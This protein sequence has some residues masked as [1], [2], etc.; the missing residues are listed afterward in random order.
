MKKTSY[1]CDLCKEVRHIANLIA[2]RIIPISIDT[3]RVQIELTDNREEIEKSDNH[4][5]FT[6]TDIIIE[7]RRKI[8]T[9]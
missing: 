9:D 4:I 5:C 1:S 7:H 2:Y 3:D 6:C 8:A